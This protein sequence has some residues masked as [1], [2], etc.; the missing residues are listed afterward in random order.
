MLVIAC[1][2]ELLFPGKGRLGILSLVTTMTARP[3]EVET[4]R[5]K[6]SESRAAKFSFPSTATRRD[7]GE[8]GN[9][10]NE[11]SDESK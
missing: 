3:G 8:R 1:H 5:S 9:Y 7:N 6:R 4:S 10:T 11:V 2:D